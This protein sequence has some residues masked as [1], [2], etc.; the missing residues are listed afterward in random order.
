MGVDAV[1][2]LNDQCD[3]V[4]KDEKQDER[5]HPPLGEKVGERLAKWTVGTPYAQTLASEQLELVGARGDGL[6]GGV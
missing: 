5:F 4:G 1:S 6:V 2:G 3:G